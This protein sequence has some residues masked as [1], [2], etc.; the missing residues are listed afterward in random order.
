MPH[1]ERYAHGF[2]PDNYASDLTVDSLS[3]LP[4]IQEVT[5]L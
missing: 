5:R 2:R 4:T 1:W 3:E